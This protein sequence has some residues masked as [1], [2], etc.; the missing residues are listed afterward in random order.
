M[1]PDEIWWSTDSVACRHDNCRTTILLRSDGRAVAVDRYA[2]ETGLSFRYS[3]CRMEILKQSPRWITGSAVVSSA[4]RAMPILPF[5]GD[6]AAP[7]STI[8][9]FELEPCVIVFHVASGFAASFDCVMTIGHR[10]FTCALPSQVPSE[11]D[12]NVDLPFWLFSGLLRG[13]VSIPE[14]IR[15]GKIQGRFEILSLLFGL[16]GSATNLQANAPDL[17]ATR[18][19]QLLDRWAASHPDTWRRVVTAGA[20]L[21]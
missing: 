8:S 19:L 3:G 13:I 7:V 10:G 1:L 20:V 4:G 14:I 21:D 2:P 5:L 18:H 12:C 17:A 16:L 15:D 11:G 6:L 9:P